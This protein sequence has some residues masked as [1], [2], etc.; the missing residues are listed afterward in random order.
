MQQE[1][2]RFLNLRHLPANVS[3]EL[4]AAYLGFAPHEIPILVGKGLLKPLGHPAQNSPKFFLMVTLEEL[5]RDEKWFGKARDA[6]A[7]FWHNKNT[8]KPSVQNQARTS[9]SGKSIPVAA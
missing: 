5:R 4:A 9:S 1:I 2:E 7:D 3:A 8:R 6:I